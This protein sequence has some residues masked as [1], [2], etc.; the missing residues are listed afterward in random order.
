[1]DASTITKNDEPVTEF[2]VDSS[3]TLCLCGFIELKTRSALYDSISSSVLESP[4]NLIYGMSDCPPLAWAV[5]DIY[6]DARA[7]LECEIDDLSSDL[8]NEIDND[9]VSSDVED[10]KGRIAALTARFEKMPEEPYEGAK[11]WV[12]GLTSKEFKSLIMPA[13]EKWLCEEP[14]SI[15]EEEYL[16]RDN[17]AQGAALEFFKEM[18][19]RKLKV[20]GVK[21]IE[22]EHPGSTYYAA[23]LHGDI[24]A[25][26]QAAVKAGIPIRFK[27]DTVA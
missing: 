24:E 23:E 2:S 7:E 13:I 21:I 12:L 5:N 25:A 22:G 26:N 8:E 16:P 4:K 10:Y 11:D 14:N 18:D 19:G 20:L 1:M 9:N 6:S 17:T 27:H 3:G 15:G